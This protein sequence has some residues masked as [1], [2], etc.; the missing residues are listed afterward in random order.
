MRMS[1]RTILLVFFAVFFAA[2]AEAKEITANRGPIIDSVQRDSTAADGLFRQG[3]QQRS[4]GQ[5]ANAQKTFERVVELQPDHDQAHFELARIYFERKELD[6]AVREA[7]RATELQGDNIAYWGGL[8]EIYKATGNFKGMI[9][10]FES[11]IRLKPTEVSHYFDKAYLL[12]ITED[13]QRALSVYDEVTKQFGHSE[14]VAFGKAQVYLAMERQKPA[15]K[16]L[17]S[18]IAKAPAENR[19]YITLAEIHSAMKNYKK[20]MSILDQAEKRFPND[21]VIWLSRADVYA[22][23]GNEEKAYQHLEKA[24]R[25]T[26]LELEAK[27]SV[28]Y[29]A[30]EEEKNIS[31]QSLARLADLLVEVAPR[32][33]QTHAIRG[34]IYNANGDLATARESF[35][36]AL[37]I[38][39][40]LE[41][42][43]IQ[44]LQIELQ[45]GLF[46]EV[47]EN[48]AQ[49]I[50]LFPDR[51]IILFFTGS[52]YL[53]NK[54]P[55]EARKYFEQALNNADQENKLLL[56]QLYGAL[57]DTYHAL[58]M[59][60]ESDVAYDE[61]IEMDD[62]NAYAMNNYAYYLA[63]RK[64]HLD[65]AEKLISRAVEL[66]P[67]QGNNED[68]YAWVLFQ[69]GRYDEALVWMERSLEN[70]EEPSEVLY[71][72]LGDILAKLGR[73]EEAVGYWE[74]AKV[75]A[76]ALGKDIDVLSKKVNERQYID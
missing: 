25:S 45:L 51:P 64:E 76:L 26:E 14:N 59:H 47:A 1:S 24:F 58:D 15:I 52:G 37:E 16:Q 2:V 12:Y 43:W 34:D 61:A 71:E 29:A 50:S 60:A 44:L 40:Y 63:V 23:Q 17:E 42:V 56:S 19:A 53:A 38:N 75:L 7:R 41:P 20:A 69:Q 74:K 10:V 5:L 65:K 13:Y 6:A 11:L 54:K 57:G 68:T 46:D 55:A 67:N 27:A 62:T 72:H 70:T 4:A 49:A 66:M 32:E 8:L 30:A 3:V 33:P 21:P 36:K 48:G 39:M 73:I 18:V 35:K 9:P 22:K 31:P 28:I